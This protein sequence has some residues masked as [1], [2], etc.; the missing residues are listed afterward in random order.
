MKRLGENNL[1]MIA[2]R[3]KADYIPKS[4]TIQAQAISVDT[5]PTEDSDNLITS[6]GVYDSLVDK[7]D[8][9]NKV[10]SLS[11]KST[12]QQYPSAKAVVDS[13]GKWGV[14][15]QTQT[16][17]GTAATGYDY[18]MSNLVHGLIPQANIDLYVAAGAVFNETTGYFELNGLTDISYKEMEI[19]YSE[20]V[21]NP[22][23]GQQGM[24]TFNYG[25]TNLPP[26]NNIGAITG[27]SA[28]RLCYGS[29][30]AESIVFLNNP[31]Q[32]AQFN[33]MQLAFFDLER[34][35]NVITELN[36]SQAT[37]YKQTF[38]RCYTLESVKLFGVKASFDIIYSPNLNLESVVYAVQNAANTTAITITLHANAYARCVA[39]TTEY[40]YNGQTYV[41]IIAYANAK[42]IT[43]ASA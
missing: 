27:F 36:V 35:K 37:N 32:R 17:T 21:P 26:K 41:G 14:I 34:L 13:L 9:S 11:A 5:T 12:H 24:F 23:T 1:A 6:G 42:N 22:W 16:W 31:T 28:L 18:T 30:R 33:N 20:Y 38:Q 3:V 29:D 43:I 8:V 25:R 7:E 4:D 40:K 39:D 19:I 2:A 15:S 10:N